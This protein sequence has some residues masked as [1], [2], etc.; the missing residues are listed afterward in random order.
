MN[1]VNYLTNVKNH[2]NVQVVVAVIGA[3]IFVMFAI[4]SLSAES[5]P[6]EQASFD[7]TEELQEE[8][9]DY[10]HRINVSA[11]SSASSSAGED[12]DDD[13]LYSDVNVEGS[14]RVN[15]EVFE[16]PEDGQLDEVVED[17]NGNKT[18]VDINIS[19]DSYS[20]S[21]DD[22]NNDGRLRIRIDADSDYDYDYDY[23][24]EYDQ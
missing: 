24:E 8:T 5:G 18:K 13:E 7:T 10:R 9:K 21:E 20:S 11:S 2:L 19:D 22:S 14:V 6:G 17:D 16:L 12:N 1:K 15:G 4:N 23:E 3:A